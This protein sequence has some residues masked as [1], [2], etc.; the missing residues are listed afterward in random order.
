M[1]EPAAA[2]KKKAIRIPLSLIAVVVLMLAVPRNSTVVHIVRSL[3][4]ESPAMMAAIVIISIFSIYWS[5]EAKNG[6]PAASS[7]SKLSRMFHLTILNGGLL[8]LILAVPGLRQ[9]ILPA[10]PAFAWAG[11]AMELAGFALA[12]W[13]RRVLGANWSGEVRIA[14]GHQLVRTGPYR[15]VRHPIYT[16]VM[17]MYGGVLLVCGE[18]HALIAVALILVAYLRKIRMEESALAAAFGEEFA[19]WRKETWAL[20][21]L[22]Y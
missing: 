7:E 12:V 18:L 3:F 15:W 1:T 6:K 16:A 9:R 5:L 14:T 8:L 13:A 17:A 22:L 21:P 10:S 20:A 4:A 2:A 19:A 11:L